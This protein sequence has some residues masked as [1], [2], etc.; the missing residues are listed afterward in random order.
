MTDSDVCRRALGCEWGRRK[1]GTLLVVCLL[2]VCV[3]KTP[4]PLCGAYPFVGY[5]GFF[6]NKLL[7]Q[8]TDSTTVF[9]LP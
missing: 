5:C 2:K 4:L 1:Q 6:I 3:V 8:K 9:I 7:S